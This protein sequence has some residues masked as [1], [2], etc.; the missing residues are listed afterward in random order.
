MKKPKTQNKGIWS[1]VYVVEGEPN[2]CALALEELKDIHSGKIVHADDSID[3]IKTLCQSFQFGS[4]GIIVLV[5]SPKSEILSALLDIAN[6]GSA[7]CAAL[8]VYY[9][10]AYAD[11]RTGFVSEAHKRNRVYEY[12]YHLVNV[13]ESFHAQLSDWE[14]RSEVKIAVKAKPWLVEHAPIKKADVRGARGSKEEMVYDIPALESDLY[15]LAAWVQTEGRDILSVDDLQL[16][17]YS[18]TANNQFDYCDAFILGSE[19]ILS[20]D[21]PDKNYVGITRMLV[22]QCHFVAQ[23]KSHRDAAWL[24]SDTVAQHIGGAECAAKYPFLDGK[25]EGYK[26]THPFRIK[27]SGQKFKNISLERVLSLIELCNIATRD[28][29]NGYPHAIIYEMMVL[30]SLNQMQYSKFTE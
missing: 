3:S 11:R 14:T 19:S 13:L 10:G 16:G 7:R 29:L 23:V 12:E 1:K 28:M 9:P 24:Q 21:L 25:S 6:S 27:M 4:Q 30:A 2:G 20:M 22:S 17:I 15:K 8:V 5:Q 18:S 26:K